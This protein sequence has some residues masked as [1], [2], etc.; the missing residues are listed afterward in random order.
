MRRNSFL[1]LTAL[2]VLIG[3]GDALHAQVVNEPR[4][5]YTYSFGGLEAME[6]G[7]AVELLDDLGYAGIA[8][9]ARGEKSLNRMSA[10]YKW[11][12]RKGDDFKVVSAIITLSIQPL[13]M[14]CPWW[15]K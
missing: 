15:K 2:L 11:S 1:V 10:F 12:E 7:D 8:V 4:S 14:P 5:L 3:V 9:E 6:V 13:R